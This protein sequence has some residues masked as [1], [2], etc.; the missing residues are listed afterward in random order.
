MSTILQ[1]VPWVVIPA[2]VKAGAGCV[3]W[4]FTVLG[5]H[6]QL[7]ALCVIG[8]ACYIG[9]ASI[10]GNDVH[11]NHGVFL[12]NHSLV[13]N[14]VLIGPNVT[15]TD[16][17]HPKVNN[18]AYHAEPPIIEDDVSIGAGATILPGVRLG[19]GCTIGAGAVVTKDVPAGE[20]WAGNPARRLVKWPNPPADGG[21]I[22]RT[23][24]IRVD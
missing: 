5:E 24:S 7:G 21:W 23:T 12:P 13:G 11:L 17:K 9:R 14:R 4:G 2:S 20:T 1:P 3:V 19:C 10:L 16:D 22:R 18:P 8:S 15:C 6:V